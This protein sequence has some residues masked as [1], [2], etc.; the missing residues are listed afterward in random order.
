MPRK[1]CFQ[2]KCHHSGRKSKNHIL[3]L[4]YSVQ[5]SIKS[6]TS[7]RPYNAYKD[8]PLCDLICDLIFFLSPDLT[9][10]PMLRLLCSFFSTL[11]SQASSQL[12]SLVLSVSP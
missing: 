11:I 9:P 2:V 4:Y 1:T 10:C 6:Q 12:M 3:I 5:M 8:L 7:Q